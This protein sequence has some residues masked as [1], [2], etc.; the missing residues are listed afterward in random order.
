MSERD[1]AL[2]DFSTVTSVC[3]MS[4]RDGAAVAWGHEVL[5]TAYPKRAVPVG[6]GVIRAFVHCRDLRL[7]ITRDL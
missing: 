2:L 1:D 5:G 7:Y 6:Y 4:R 3:E